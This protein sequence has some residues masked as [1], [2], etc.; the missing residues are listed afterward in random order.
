MLH[1]DAYPSA[2]GELLKLFLLNVNAKIL[3]VLTANY[4]ERFTVL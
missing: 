2:K 3:N 4:S 1:N